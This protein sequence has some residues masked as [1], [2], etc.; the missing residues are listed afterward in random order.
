MWGLYKISLSLA[1]L[2]LLT[3]PAKPKS[4]FPTF[5]LPPKHE[6]AKYRYGLLLVL[7]AENNQ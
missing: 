2:L 6:S 7:Y 5:S 4:F 3:I 1:L